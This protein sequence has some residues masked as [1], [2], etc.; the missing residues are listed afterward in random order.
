[1][2]YKQ[3]IKEIKNTKKAV[4]I[5]SQECK[6]GQNKVRIL[7]FFFCSSKKKL[8]DLVKKNNAIG[9]YVVIERNFYS[10]DYE[11]YIKLISEKQEVKQEDTIYFELNKSATILYKGAILKI[12]EILK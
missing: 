10:N 7:R 12:V 4:L 1:M 2:N 9:F 5:D 3:L 11:V 8:D 6:R